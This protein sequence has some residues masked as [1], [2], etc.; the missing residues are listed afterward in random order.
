MGATELLIGVDGG[1]TACRTRLAEPGGAIL[2]EC[3]GG[4][5]N[6][7]DFAGA[8]GR[9]TGVL[10]DLLARGGVG[11]GDLGAASVHLGLAGVTGPVIG[12]RVRAALLGALP[13]GRVTVGGDTVT[14]VIG[15]LGG[16]D[17]AVAAVGTGSFVGR[18]LGGRVATL[19][20]RGFLLGDQASG[21]WLGKR[22]LQET[23]LAADGLRGH[24][25]LSRAVLARHGGDLARV[26]GFA[27]SAPPAGFAALAPEVLAAANGGD[28]LARALVAEGADY[29]AR[30]LDALGWRAGEGLCLAGGLGPHYRAWLPEGAQASLTEARG[31]ALDGAMVLAAR[32]V[33]PE[34]GR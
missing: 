26:I 18:S 7:S 30:A 33:Q 8:V 28:A 3:A 14:T 21:A 25:G 6:V 16:A 9:L 24:S 15:A 31:G 29:I 22:L 5:A 34:A 23:M 27:L 32:S 12:D 10:G 4:P 2:A 1:G 17:G 19:G 13:F 11:R 20:G